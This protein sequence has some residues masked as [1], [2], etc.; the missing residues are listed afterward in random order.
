M[1]RLGSLVYRLE[2]N[3]KP[4]SASPRVGLCQ[5]LREPLVSSNWDLLDAER[6]TQKIEDVVVRRGRGHKAVS[7]ELGHAKSGSWRCQGCVCCWN[8]ENASG[9]VLVKG[10]SQA[11]GYLDLSSD[12]RRSCAVDVYAERGSCEDGINIVNREAETETSGSDRLTW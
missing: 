5:C 2:G 7:M 3:P 12:L 6:G 11:L 4:S 8:S 9:A 10:H 1:G